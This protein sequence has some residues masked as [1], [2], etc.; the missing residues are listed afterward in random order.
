MSQVWGKGSGGRRHSDQRADLLAEVHYASRSTRR[1]FLSFLVQRA[2]QVSK[3]KSQ[4][5][6]FRS[7]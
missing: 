6:G 1:Y 4:H 2:P 5:P 3:L 7:Y